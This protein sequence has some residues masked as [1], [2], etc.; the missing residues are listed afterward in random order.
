MTD[1]PTVIIR[2]NRP[3]TKAQVTFRTGGVVR[4]AVTGCLWLIEQGIRASGGTPVK[5][6]R[7]NRD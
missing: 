6:C 3:G 1:A 5:I 7:M 2:R 4:E